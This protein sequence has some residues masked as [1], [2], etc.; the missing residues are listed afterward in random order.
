MES[1]PLLKACKTFIG[2]RETNTF[3]LDCN[4]LS[5]KVT[6]KVLNLF[7]AV[8]SSSYLSNLNK[9]KFSACRYE[10][11][12]KRGKRYTILVILN[13]K[14]IQFVEHL[15]TYHGSLTTPL[16]SETVTLDTTG[17]QYVNFRGLQGSLS[18][19]LHCNP[20]HGVLGK[21]FWVFPESVY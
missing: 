20:L 16:C 12:W 2:K 21:L 4:Q 14:G 1:S 8:S 7:H 9:K 6:Y 18:D 17:N 10:G 3:V 19:I 5:N 15:Y 13:L 11:D